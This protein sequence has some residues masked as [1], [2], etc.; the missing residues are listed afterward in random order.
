MTSTLECRPPSSLE[1]NG[2][3][4]ASHRARIQKDKSYFDIYQSLVPFSVG[5]LTVF[6]LDRDGERAKPCRQCLRSCTADLADVPSKRVGEL[7]VRLMLYFIMGWVDAEGHT[8]TFS[9]TL[10]AEHVILG[11]ATGSSQ[12]MP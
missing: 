1:T 7:P 9:F 11:V 8:C 10:V 4:L 3:A 5:N 2:L 12:Y 6:P